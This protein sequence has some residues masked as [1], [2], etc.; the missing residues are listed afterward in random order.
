MN[1][2]SE[3]VRALSIRVL[4]SSHEQGWVRLEVAL[5]F[6]VGSLFK[7]RDVEVGIYCD[8]AE[9]AV[10]QLDNQG[11]WR[12]Y[13]EGMEG[14]A[15]ELIFEAE[16]RVSL[17]RVR[18]ERSRLTYQHTDAPRFVQSNTPDHP[19]EL[20]ET[21]SDVQLYL[22]EMVT[23]K[24]GNSWIGS[25]GVAHRVRVS[26]PLAVSPVPVTQG[27]YEAV[28]GNNP[29]RFKGVRNPVERVSFW[30]A[31]TFCNRL[32]ELCNHAPAYRLYEEKDRRCI[33]WL[34]S[35]NGFRIPSEAEWE[36]LARAGKDHPYSGGTFLAK[37]GWYH[38]NAMS[39]TQEVAQKEPNKFGL[40]DMSGNVWE[41][42]FDE[43]DEGIYLPRVGE[44][45]TDPVHN[46]YPW[47]RRKVRRGGCWLAYPP[48]CQVYYR[49]HA[50]A[51]Y[52]GDDTGFRILRT[53]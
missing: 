3:Q 34:R 22:P 44:L 9:I 2:W 37:V 35:S 25:Q 13:I 5:E 20:K 51:T 16:A 19:E 17:G 11:M 6:K 23:V 46:P 43:W 50:L 45:S 27:L 47:A 39:R 30:D 53:I 31:V 21:Q 24:A 52:E 41:W 40:Y 38:D 4:D 1:Q 36:Y 10:A 15:H 26:R 28:M 18:T 49:F 42:C 8:G 33:E 29:S 12:G 14:P 48:N 32:S 7:Q